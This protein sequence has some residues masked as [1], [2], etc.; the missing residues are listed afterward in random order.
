MFILIFVSFF[1]LF[2]IGIALHAFTNVFF[3]LN[4]DNLHNQPEALPKAWG[5]IKRDVLEV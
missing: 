1:I 4:R 2:C 3:F 5:G